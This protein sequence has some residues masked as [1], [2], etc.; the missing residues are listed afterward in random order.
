MAKTNGFTV[1]QA[2]RV[3]DTM[4]PIVDSLAL[5]L[6]AFEIPEGETLPI[7]ASKLHELYEQAIPVYL[8]D[9]EKATED[10][11]RAEVLTDMAEM[12]GMGALATI[13]T[14]H[15]DPDLVISQVKEYGFHPKGQNVVEQDI[16]D[17]L[18]TLREH[19]DE[20][21]RVLTTIQRENS[22]T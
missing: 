10:E 4:K 8:A 3:L 14:W 18:D 7:T 16:R 9:N 20:A 13:H 21:S 11:A 12:I 19:F 22:L 2:E 15:E 5:N 17:E 1:E 6:A